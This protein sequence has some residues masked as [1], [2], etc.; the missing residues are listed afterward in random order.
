VA[1][2]ETALAAKACEPEVMSS[3]ERMLAAI[4]FFI[5]NGPPKG[6]NSF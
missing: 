2:L 1:I 3:K 4:V 5:L 6:L